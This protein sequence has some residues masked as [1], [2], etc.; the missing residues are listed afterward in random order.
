MPITV[1]NIN[2]SGPGSLREAI[3][4]VEAGETIEFAPGLA[5]EV[6]RL[7][8]QL[9]IN[10]DITIVGLVDG[11]NNPNI[12]ISGNNASR[13]FDIQIDDA[14]NSPTVTLQNIIIADGS[15]NNT[16]ENGAGAGIRTATGTTLRVENVAFLNNQAN[17]EGGGAI[18]AGLRSSNTIVN[19]RFEGNGTL[20]NGE[21][22]KSER[23]GGAIAV[24]SESTTAVID[25]TF[26]NNR[27]VNGGA[28]NTLLGSLTV[29][30]STFTTNDTAILGV[31]LGSTLGYGGAIYTDGASA[32]N[33][34]STSGTILIRNSRFN[35][36][37][38]A[39][40]GG[41]LFLFAYPGDNVIVE[42]SAIA[43][44]IVVPDTSGFGLGGGLRYGGGGEL[45]ITKTTFANNTAQGQGGGF[46]VGEN[47]PVAIE[48]STF[49]GNQ[50]NSIGGVVGLGGAIA[51]INGSA[52]T[53][54]T[55][56]TIAN[57]TAGF[58]GGGFWGD[59]TG[60]TLTN[61]IV[62]YNRG[63]DG[64][65]VNH[66]T[67]FVF[68]DGGGNI[69]S[70]E[71]NPNDTLVT[72]GVLL[73]DPLLGDLQ[74]INGVLVHPLLEG[75]PAV[76]AG[77]NAG[78]PATDQRGQVRPVD[79]DN[80]GTLLVDSGAYELSDAQF[81]INLDIDNN[82][83]TDALT[84][85][86]LVIRYLF[87]LTGDP[88]IEG[89]VGAGAN[90]STASDIIDYLD[91]ARN[92]MLDVDDNGEASALID[93]LLIVRYLLGLTGEPLVREAIAP[94]ANRTSAASIETFL[95]SFDLPDNGLTAGLQL[96]SD[97]L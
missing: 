86:I 49:S 28:I 56:S 83:E 34:A 40:Q 75:S 13:V 67:G 25:S 63:I 5:G 7:N 2:D 18:F 81:P 8:G 85:G 19:S 93:G 37:T 1:T 46:W 16:G 52:T 84:D 94:D 51:L 47:S 27:G 76:D 31:P 45:E 20:G 53:T 35:G 58:Q 71:L 15:T 54:I 21:F 22:G 42:D 73:A 69:Q 44:N 17:G 14:F 43:D 96:N 62:A 65:N 90:R 74:E 79:G 11:E 55:N 24:K 6:I 60:T 9:E 38:G 36:N 29:E 89:V 66:H 97:F 88:L 95:Q 87:G 12:T 80:N 48:N 68:R 39:G 10:K 32:T 23:G 82:G 77:V 70:N 41:G 72:P 92:P 4:L 59:A 50:A 91:S 30:N 3:A 78:A 61:T 33:N 64:F 57:N 26:T